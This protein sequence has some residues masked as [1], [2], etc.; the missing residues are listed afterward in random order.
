[1]SSEPQ[2]LLL[3]NW[4]W[5]RIT[6][7][8]SVFRNYWFA[9]FKVK[10]TVKDHI[11]KR[12]LS[13]ESSELLILLQLNMVWLHIIIG[14]IVLWKNKTALLWSRI[15]SQ[16]RFRI[17]ENVHLGDISSTAEPFLTT[18][19]IVMHH[20]GPVCHVWRLICCLQ[21]H[22]HSKGSYN[23]IWLFQPYP[24]YCWS[25]ATR[26]NGMVHHHKLECLVWKL[27]FCF[28]CLG[29]SESS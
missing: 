29:H 17:P 1:M 20:H 16:E 6:M 26:F 7:S 19:G 11:I 9:V 24:L 8:Q 12:W 2:I 10:V 18:L 27:D 13:N 14:W 22:D 4:V 23:Q 5:W 3:P 21:G 25:F 15:R 28:Q